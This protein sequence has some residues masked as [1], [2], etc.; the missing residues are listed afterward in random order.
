MELIASNHQ[1]V[2]ALVL[3]PRAPTKLNFYE[4]PSKLTAYVATHRSTATGPRSPPKLATL[5]KN[6]LRISDELA[7]PA[8]PSSTTLP[9]NSSTLLGLKFWLYLLFKSN[10]HTHWM[11]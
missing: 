6:H 2:R 7:L 10:P 8:L 3:R 9:A 4:A 5:A 1:H 11:C